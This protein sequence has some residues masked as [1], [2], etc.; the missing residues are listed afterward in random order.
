MPFRGLIAMKFPITL[1]QDEDRMW[2]ADEQ[3]VGRGIVDEFFHRRIPGKRP[4]RLE[5]APVLADGA[6][7]R[8]PLPEPPRRTRTTL[9]T[10]LVIPAAFL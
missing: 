6:H 4:P 1:T 2:V 8:P 9:N 10:R 5:H 3:G 7:E